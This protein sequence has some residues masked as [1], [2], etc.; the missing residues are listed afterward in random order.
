M[1]LVFVNRCKTFGKKYSSKHL[2][3]KYNFN[4]PFNNTEIM[5]WIIIQADGTLI[6]LDII[7]ENCHSVMTSCYNEC[8]ASEK[9][10]AK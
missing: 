4:G 7:N 5:N 2:V 3:R 6:P 9:N 1:K 8:E 10:I